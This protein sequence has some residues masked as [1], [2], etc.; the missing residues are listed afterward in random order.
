MHPRFRKLFYPKA[1]IEDKTFTKEI[2]EE[3]RLQQH[4]SSKKDNIGLQQNNNKSISIDK[5]I[6]KIDKEQENS[7][8]TSTNISASPSKNNFEFTATM[9]PQAVVST[10]A[11]PTNNLQKNLLTTRSIQVKIKSFLQG[12]ILFFYMVVLPT[13]LSILYYGFIASNVY[14][15][16]SRFIVKTTESS[17]LLNQSFSQM[18]FGQ[19]PKESFSVHD[20]IMSRDAMLILNKKFDIKKM[21]SV[22]SFDFITKFPG[23][24]LFDKSIEDFHLYYQK[25]IVEVKVDAAT[26]ISTLYV[27]SFDSRLSFEIN[28]QLLVLS[29]VLVNTLSERARADMLQS[30]QQ[31]VEIAK[32]KIQSISARVNEMRSQ[33]VITDPNQHVAQLQSFYNEKNFAKQQLQA[34]LTSLESARSEAMKKQ[35]YLETI[36]N[37]KLPD[38]AMEPR[39]IRAVLGVLSVSLIIW[40]IVALMVS[41]IKE[42]QV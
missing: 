20:Y 22:A 24:W 13:I 34:A 39:R 5:K 6:N 3:A 36:A 35:I 9:S 29:E 28:Q 17:G 12:N 15:T 4:E 26:S 23:I 11:V 1:L 37:P 16:E 10:S 2:N 21:Y 8:T 42:H 33:T 7:L 25:N 18:V 14:V 32:E 41:G 19:S 40:G 30:S 27:R 31:E 38:A